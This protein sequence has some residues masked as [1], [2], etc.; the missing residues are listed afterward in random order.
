MDLFRLGKPNFS[1]IHALDRRRILKAQKTQLPDCRNSGHIHDRSCRNIFRIFK[2]LTRTEYRS[3]T[4]YRNI[5]RRNHKRSVLLYEAET[6]IVLFSQQLITLIRIFLSGDNTFFLE[7]IK[8]FQSL[9][10]VC[11]ACTGSTEFNNR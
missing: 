2:Y 8:F 6:K 7:F 4:L 5:Y 1:D 10:I 11:R 3:V 9:K